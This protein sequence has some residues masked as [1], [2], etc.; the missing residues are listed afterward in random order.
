VNCGR[1]W[2]TS[3][4]RRNSSKSCRQADHQNA[5]DGR[6]STSGGEPDPGELPPNPE[7]IQ[8]TRIGPPISSGRPT[9]RRPGPWAQS[10]YSVKELENAAGNVHSSHFG[11]VLG[12]LLVSAKLIP[13]R[14]QE[15]VGEV[16]FAPRTES[17]V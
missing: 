1:N 2:Q 3:E 9:H 4:K 14:G 7:V 11:F 13:H 16:G 5:I 6:L 12:F 8:E 10:V 17:L 15:L